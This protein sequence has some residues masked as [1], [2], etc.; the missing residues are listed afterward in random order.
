VIA[1]LFSSNCTVLGFGMAQDLLKLA[2]SFPHVPGFRRHANLVDLQTHSVQSIRT[3]FVKAMVAS[4]Q[5]LVGVLLEIRMD[6]D[7]QCR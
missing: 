4:L 7:E 3:Q 5:K 6:K 2:A 1:T